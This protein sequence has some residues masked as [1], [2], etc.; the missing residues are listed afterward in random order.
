VTLSKKAEALFKAIDDLMNEG[1]DPGGMTVAQIACRAGIGKGT[2]YEY[3]KNKEELIGGAIVYKISGICRE[4]QIEMTKKPNLLA[5]LHYI[6]DAIDNKESEKAA[7]LKVVN[8][9]TDTSPLSRQIEK[10]IT[11]RIGDMYMPERIVLE[12]I[13]QAQREGY[14]ISNKPVSYLKLNVA[15][16]LLAYTMYS[17]MPAYEMDCDTE[18]M[19]RLV[20]EGIIK[21][22]EASM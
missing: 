2:T 17:L 15:A 8:I 18:T 19:R 12:L 5:M 1:Q 7:F 22:F 16:K 4:I 10:I 13:E 11:E 14:E 9:V 3:F 6:F 20:C 21:E